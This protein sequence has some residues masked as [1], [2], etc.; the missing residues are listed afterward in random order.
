MITAPQRRAIHR[1]LDLFEAAGL[2]YQCTGG[3]AGILHGSKWPLHDLDLD[4]AKA[5]MPYVASVLGAAVTRAAGAYRDG[6]FDL[7]LLQA[8][9]DGLEIDVSQVEGARILTASGWERMGTD[10][11]RRAIVSWDGRQVPA[12]P[13]ADLIAYKRRLPGRVLDVEELS[14]L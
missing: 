5:D 12:I 14:T 2:R 7:V 8:A 4:V 3:F 11:S 9:V 10:L 6:E 13:L 1:V